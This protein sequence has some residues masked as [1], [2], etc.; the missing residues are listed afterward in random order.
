MENFLITLSDEYKIYLYYYDF[1]VSI[2][3]ANLSITCSDEQPSKVAVSFKHNKEIARYINFFVAENQV[4]KC[5]DNKFYYDLIYKLLCNVVDF[6]DMSER[7]DKYLY[8]ILNLNPYVK[9]LYYNSNYKILISSNICCPFIY[10]KGKNNCKK[11]LLDLLLNKINI[12]N[13]KEGPITYRV[14]CF[15]DEMKEEDIFMHLNKKDK[16]AFLMNKESL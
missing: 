7:Q 15:H 6:C 16:V 3:D 8:E 10:T 13:E 2:K 12:Y 9:S 1:K 14:F 5:I 4:A 11:D